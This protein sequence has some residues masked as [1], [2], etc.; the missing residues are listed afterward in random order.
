MNRSLPTSSENQNISFRLLFCIFLFLCGMTSFQTK[1]ENV[2]DRKIQISKTK[3]TVYELLKHIS[4]QVD[5]T[6]VYDSRILDND[7]K[8]K[9]KKGEYSIRE[10][11]Y[12]VVQNDRLRL[13]VKGNHILLSLPGKNKGNIPSTGKS[14]SEKENIKDHLVLTGKI[15]N[16][17]TNKPV[18]S[19]SVGIMNT[20]IGTITNQEGDFR[21]IIPDSLKM[22]R[23]RFSCIGYNTQI[24]EIDTLKNKHLNLPLSPYTVPLREVTVSL[25][26]P[27]EVID[28]IKKRRLINYPTNPIYLTSFYREG[29]EYKD[30]NISL[31][32]A[33]LRIYK[34]GYQEGI[35]HDEAKMIKMRHTYNR[36]TNDTLLPK[37]KSGINSCFQL[38]IMKNMPDFI[39]WEITSN[40]TYM[41]SG[42]DITNDRR[43][44]I[45]SFK[46]KDFIEKP[47]YKGQLYV[48]TKNYAVLEARFEIDPRYIKEATYSYVE[49]KSP[50]LNLELKKAVYTV[51][52]KMTEDSIHYASHIRG[53]LLFSVKSKKESQSQPMLFWFEMVN[54]K[55]DK[56]DIKSFKK[57]ERLPKDK[58]LSDIEY[59]YD[60]NFWG[61]F[62][63]IIPEDRLKETIMNN[64]NEIVEYMDE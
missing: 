41:H 61:H 40:Y 60:K 18:I 44:D 28:N 36:N 59:K 55:V 5:Y 64:L 37:M 19:A 25:L 57:N 8:I 48:D 47:L 58:I 54:C 7:K 22:G 38:D 17:T 12:N 43:I 3:G 35:D 27:M 15:Y 16:N 46:Q 11:I 52:Y 34:T 13:M 62:N 1:S 30:N 10:A 49:K 31:T 42:V 2:L 32:E 23:I 20:T 53:D 6:F 9:I 24:I 50:K 29:V 21:L 63:I 4:E 14:R 39:S 26:N 56:N 51:S 45:I 33:V